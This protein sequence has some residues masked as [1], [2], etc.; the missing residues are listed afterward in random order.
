MVAKFSSNS[1]P[2][3]LFAYVLYYMGKAY[4]FPFIAMERNACG[5]SVF[6]SLC[7]TVFQYPNVIS[8]NPQ[9]RPG[10]YSHPQMKIRA[11]L[12]AQSITSLCS[13]HIVIN[14]GQLLEELN[15]F[16][17]KE[18]TRNATY[19]AAKGRHDDHVLSFIWALFAMER[20]MLD[21]YYLP[22]WKE[23]E[24]KQTYAEYVLPASNPDPKRYPNI[25]VMRQ[26][27]IAAHGKAFSSLF[28]SFPNKRTRVSSRP[29]VDP[30]FGDVGFDDSP[31][32]SPDLA[33]RDLESYLEQNRNDAREERE[34]KEMG[35]DSGDTQMPNNF[36]GIGSL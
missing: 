31:W 27:D 1:V 4:G 28:S 2:P 13:Y 12:N 32:A 21:R 29:K 19:K 14:D 30:I 18:G 24:F 10:I 34:L 23:N 20:T 22:Q 7:T 9:S 16:E 25:D 36:F 11:C 35:Y 8:E 5:G 15:S 17:R 6:D 33:L 3:T 26:A